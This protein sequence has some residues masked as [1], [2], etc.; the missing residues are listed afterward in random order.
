MYVAILAGGT[1]SGK[2][3]AAR[4]LEARGCVRIDLD[5]L[6]RHVLDPGTHTTRAVAEAFGTDLLDPMTGALDRGLLAERAFATPEGARLLEAIELPDIYQLLHDTL[7]ELAGRPNPPDACIVEVPL[8]DRVECPYDI[9][10]EVVV[11]ACPR[12]LRRERAIGRGMS[13]SDFDARV[14]HQPSDAW[15]AEHADTVIDNVGSL[16]DLYTAL[17]HWY[18]AHERGGWQ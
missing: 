9:A 12:A 2:S 8:L 15:L 4:W 16:D 13:G 14:A 10:Q 5:E 3:A 17:C 6:S 1:G 7:E 18:D 11:I